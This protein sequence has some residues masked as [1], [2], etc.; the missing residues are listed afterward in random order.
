[1]KVKYSNDYSSLS[2]DEKL[3]KLEDTC[4]DELSY[5]IDDGLKLDIEKMFFV[6]DNI[7]TLITINKGYDI[8]FLWKDIEDDI[9]TLLTLLNSK[10]T[11]LR[12]YGDGSPQI[13]FQYNDNSYKLF[14][15]DNLL[16][17]EIIKGKIQELKIR[18]YV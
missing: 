10:Y 5:L 17:N 7:K 8:D 13:S 15:L 16:N 12:W 3:K 9:I 6:D 14:E 1:M 2:E 11:L 4:K 18:L